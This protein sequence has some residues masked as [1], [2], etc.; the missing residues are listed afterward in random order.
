MVSGSDTKQ[1]ATR[2]QPPRRHSRATWLLRRGRYCAGLAHSWTCLLLLCLVQSCVL[3]GSDVRR[4]R[5]ARGAAAAAVAALGR[6]ERVMMRGAGCGARLRGGDG[7]G[8]GDW[9]GDDDAVPRP[10]HSPRRAPAHRSWTDVVRQSPQSPR[11][12]VQS[13]QSPQPSARLRTPSVRSRTPSVNVAAGNSPLPVGLGPEDAVHGQRIPIEMLADL[14]LDAAGIDGGTG[15]EEM[16][17]GHDLPFMTDAE[18][19]AAAALQQGP[20]TRAGQDRELEPFKCDEDLGQFEGG[21]EDDAE[22]QLDSASKRVKD[23][24]QFKLNEEKFGIKTDAWKE[25]EYT[26]PI[27][28]SDPAYPE[29]VKR[30]EQLA[31]EIEGTWVDVGATTMSNM[32]VRDERNLPL[33]VDL[34][35]AT[36]YST[37]H[38]VR[39]ADPVADQLMHD[40]ADGYAAAAAPASRDASSSAAPWA[41]DAEAE[42]EEEMNSH[43]VEEIFANAEARFKKMVEN[44]EPWPP[45]VQAIVDSIQQQ[46]GPEHEERQERLQIQ[47][48][49]G[50]KPSEVCVSKET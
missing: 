16:G 26:A 2:M 44:N 43:E 39:P 27:D 33:P 38:P 40:E 49:P 11:P 46:E 13:P 19:R 1:Q 25:E 35:E 14:D 20:G 41:G 42:E 31:A 34:D 30:A 17:A 24:D 36:L 37:V 9:A 50:W 12:A 18:I 6:D 23:F 32:H 5:Q 8:D 29:Q 3:L 10:P 45:E 15:A 48:P 21:L 4:P 22:A 28:K 47:T 7:D